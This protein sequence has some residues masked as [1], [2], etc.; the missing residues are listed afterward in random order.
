[1]PREIGKPRPV[2]LITVPVGVPPPVGPVAA[3]GGM[4]TTSGV[5]VGTGT[6]VP[7]YRVDR[8]VPLSDTHNG[9]PTAVEMPHGFRRLRS[10]C[11]AIPGM[12]ETRFVWVNPRVRYALW[13]PAPAA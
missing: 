8:P 13:S 4:V 9:R 5:A 7:S 6:P 2:V 10:R 3:A 11:A 12:F 1:M